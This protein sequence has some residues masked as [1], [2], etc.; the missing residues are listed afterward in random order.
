METKTQAKPRASQTVVMLIVIVLLAG[1]FVY[2]FGYES[3][4]TSSLN[5]QVSSLNFQNSQLATL[6]EHNEALCLQAVLL[7]SYMNATL[8]NQIQNESSLVRILN[9]TRPA[10]YADMIATLK[11]QIA[12]D[13]GFLVNYENLVAEGSYGCSGISPGT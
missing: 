7:L 4:L 12:Q 10:G 8:S 1:G 11:S 6:L 2:Y 5:G 9:S 3:G 13:T